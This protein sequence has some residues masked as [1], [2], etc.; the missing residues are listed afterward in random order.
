MKNVPS[1]KI[2]LRHPK[3]GL[4]WIV[5]SNDLAYY[6]RGNRNFTIRAPYFTENAGETDAHAFEGF[7]LVFK[8][9]ATVKSTNSEA[10]LSLTA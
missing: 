8:R 5:N 3:A 4:R 6:V 9:R 2:V 1:G 10:E 7:L